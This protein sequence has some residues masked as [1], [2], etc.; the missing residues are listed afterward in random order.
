M[1]EILKFLKDNPT[2]YVAT[3]DENGDPQLRPFGTIAK[4]GESLYI[5][6]GKVKDCY[7]QM[8]AHPRIAICTC[9][10]DGRWVRLEADTVPDDSVETCEAMLEQYPGLRD[11]YAPGDGN[12]V[13]MKL[14]NVTATIYSFTEAPKTYTF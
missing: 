1:D 3:V 4:I 6:T 11:S 8:E 5:Q 12:C 9:S 7:K 2:Y 10:N 13:A 14:Q